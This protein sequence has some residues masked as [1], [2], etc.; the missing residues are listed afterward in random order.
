MDADASKLN[1]A[2]L[3][4]DVQSF[5]IDSR[6]VRAGEVFLRSHNPNSKT[7]VS[8][9]IFKTRINMFRRLLKKMRSP[10]L[11]EPTDLPNIA[12]SWKIQDRLILLKTRLLRFKNWRTAFISNGINRL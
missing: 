12:P 11:H 5:A 4:K 10:V 3:Q 9:A 6:E 7:I 8:T 2:L 1:P